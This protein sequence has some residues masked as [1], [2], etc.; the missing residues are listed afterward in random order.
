MSFNFALWG[1]FKNRDE[2][3]KFLRLALIFTFMISICAL[4][5]PL[6]DVIF[7]TMVG[8][9]WLPYARWVSLFFLVPAL[10][11]YGKMV[12][13]FPRNKMFYGLCFIGVFCLALFMI[14]MKCAES[15]MLGW[16]WYAFSEVFVSLFIALFWSLV[17]DIST[18]ED[19]KQGY[20]LIILG[21]QFGG[22]MAPLCLYPFVSS[23]SPLLILGVISVSLFVVAGLMSWFMRVTPPA[24]LQGFCYE[25][26][27]KKVKNKTGFFEGLKLI[28]QESY[29]LGILGIITLC[30]MI[31]IIL[32]YHVKIKAAHVYIDKNQLMEFFF[33]LTLYAN[34]VAFISL[35]LGVGA[36]GRYLGVG[37]SLLLLPITVTFGVLVMGSTD[38]LA[39]LMISLVALKGISYAL[40]KPTREQLYVPTSVDVKYKAKS[41][42]DSFGS[43]VSK[44]LGSSVHMLRPVLQSEFVYVSSLLCLGLVGVWIVAAVYIARMHK[45]AV[46]E[47]KLVC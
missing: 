16:A 39:F 27:H 45:R 32:E 33:K 43:R 37:R 29:L 4:F 28:I 40:D 1:N 23:C 26:A 21:A 7:I 41:W 3:L 36:I 18:P 22:V 25:K 47:N 38:H 9:K 2:C 8:V 35:L 10:I 14:F 6:K 15:A 42:I 11:L 34:T 17:A 24:L 12:D 13:F 30:D 46:S 5:H 31:I 20:S 44:G 19:A